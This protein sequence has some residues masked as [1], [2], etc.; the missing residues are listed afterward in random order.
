LKQTYFANEE[1][2]SIASVL[3]QKVDQ[4]Y[5]FAKSSNQYARMRKSWL[6]YYGLSSNGS[7]ARSDQITYGGEQGELKFIK[8]N[9][10]RNLGQHVLTLTTTQRPVPNPVASNT[11]NKS[12]IQVVLATGLLDYYSREKRVERNLIQA[13]EQAIVVSEAYVSVTWDAS[14]GK[15][16]EYDP[17]SN[18]EVK[19]GDLEVA[20]LTAFDVI[21]DPYE[22]NSS[23]P[24][25]RIGRYQV[26]KY[27]LAAKFP[28]YADEI[29]S[30]PTV[31]TDTLRFGPTFG[32]VDTDQV[33]VFVFYHKKTAAVPEGRQVIFI[34][35]GHA[36][37][38][39]PLP[40]TGIPIRRIAPSDVM[41]SN[42]G[43][44]PMFDLLAIQE[45][46]D[47]LYTAVTTNQL[48][49]GVQNIWVPESSNL[50]FEQL[51]TGLN[52]IKTSGAKPEPLTL[53]ST[54]AE[55]FAYIK[56]LEEVME[57]L[58]G[59][60]S[61]VRGNPESSLKSGSAL[62]LV[63]AQ[64]VQFSSG[65]QA[66]Y[67]ALVEDVYTDIINILKQF[68]KT[69]RVAMIVGKYNQHLLKEF[70][71]DDLSLIS[72]VVV[73]VGNPM[74]KSIAGRQTIADSMLERGMLKTPE[75]YIA[76]MNTGKLE[77]MTEAQTRELILIRQE[78]ERL[79]SGIPC[80][81]L[82]VDNHMLHIKE[83]ASVLMDPE[84]RNDSPE[85]DA[86]LEAAMLHLTEHVT[87]AS[88][89]ALQNLLL[90]LGFQPIMPPVPVETAAGGTPANGA[91]AGPAED[92]LAQAEQ[93]ELPTNPST[94]QQW[95]PVDGGAPA[96]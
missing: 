94:G 86:I 23:N 52:L 21:R 11:D 5:S 47:A 24:N 6:A 63:Q 90:A 7:L 79:A 78:N 42:A 66:S 18:S 17:E 36:L 88:D 95:N 74:S 54:P 46:I 65:L 91:P 93:P 30:L 39:M 2:Q 38:D 70:N 92:P 75:Q 51:A 60:N 40:Y 50:N 73:D 13:A 53:L 31:E 48:A 59:V 22:P 55:V 29:E 12:H 81:V 34:D 3:N 83:N 25:W 82:A 69:K 45:A 1:P 96:P 44:T 10:F 9:H 19:E 80:K 76:F 61:T 43:Y 35:G 4:F 85:N 33:Y 20:N 15:T 49:F 57:T 58:S 84:L 8:V 26:S 16:Y 32:T 62:A 14:L 67:A 71:G 37:A 89:P 28:V 41:G 77:S 64:A 87:L 56:Q 68:A 27:E 72:R